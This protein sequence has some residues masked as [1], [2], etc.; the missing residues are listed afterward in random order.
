VAGAS[1]AGAP[2]AASGYQQSRSGRALGS[3]SGTGSLPGISMSEVYPN[4]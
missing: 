4:V 1:S 2:S 3:S